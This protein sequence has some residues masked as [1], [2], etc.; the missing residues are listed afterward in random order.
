MSLQQYV[1]DSFWFTSRETLDR[2]LLANRASAFASVEATPMFCADLSDSVAFEI[3][4]SVPE[5]Q[6][7]FA[8]LKNRI[9]HVWAVV[10]TYDRRIY[11]QIYAREK[12]IIN[13]FEGMDFDF[14]VVPSNGKDPRHLMS[15]PEIDLAY[16]RR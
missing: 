10:P 2:D 3:G 6:A 14:N 13:Q 5:V 8:S 7:V 12:K 1:D 16:L 9:L 4:Y 15:D 11:R